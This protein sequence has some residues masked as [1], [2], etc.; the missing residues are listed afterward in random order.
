MNKGG[1][2]SEFEGGRK[3]EEEAKGERQII[4]LSRQK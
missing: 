2:E 1:E 3:E 4:D